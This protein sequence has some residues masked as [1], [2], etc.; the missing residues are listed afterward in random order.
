MF[1]RSCF[2]TTG[3]R[4][5][6]SGGRATQQNS[7]VIP[8]YR[9][10]RRLVEHHWVFWQCCPRLRSVGRVVHAELVSVWLK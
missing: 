7:V 4:V 10:S 8:T 9:C 1:R 3:P 6:A 2:L 5:A